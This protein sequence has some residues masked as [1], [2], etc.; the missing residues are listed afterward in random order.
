LVRHRGRNLGYEF[1]YADATKATKSM[2]VA[3]ADLKLD[4]LWVIYPGTRGYSLN[5]KMEA[6]GLAEAIAELG[7]AV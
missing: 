1:K 4:R 5:A 3:A 6:I 2:H 7:R